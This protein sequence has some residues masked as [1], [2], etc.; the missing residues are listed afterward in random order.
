[1]MLYKIMLSLVVFGAVAGYVNSTGMYSV[2]APVSGTIGIG[3]AQVTDMSNNIKSASVNP[4]F[5]VTLLW[6]CLN[7]LFSAA[8]ALLTVIPFLTAWGV[9]PG[10][11]LMVQTPVWLVMAWGIYQMS[12]GHETQGMD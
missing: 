9:P 8:L 4:L 5:S 3:E 10:L 1:M 11:A 7:V 12:T 6:V 2:H